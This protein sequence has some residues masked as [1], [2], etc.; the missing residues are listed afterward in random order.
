MYQ[1]EHP[2]LSCMDVILSALAFYPI[3]ER[4]M[5][6]NGLYSVTNLFYCALT[7]LGVTAAV[8]LITEYYTA[9]KFAPVRQIA[10]ASTTGHGTN[11]IKGLAV[12]MQSTAAH[13]KAH[14][15]V[16]SGFV[17]TDLRAAGPT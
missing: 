4:L 10:E 8:V 14:R 2:Q 1:S 5:L 9:K 13:A 6:S 16:F 7:G 3:T 11:I 15:L 12:G 17:R